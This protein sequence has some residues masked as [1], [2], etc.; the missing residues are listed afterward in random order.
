M[1]QTIS[2]KTVAPSMLAVDIETKQKFPTIDTLP[3][4]IEGVTL[5][6]NGVAKNTINFEREEDMIVLCLSAF[7]HDYVHDYN[8]GSMHSRVIRGNMELFKSLNIPIGNKVIK[9]MA[10][11]VGG[12]RDINMYNDEMFINDSLQTENKRQFSNFLENQEDPIEIKGGDADMYRSTEPIVSEYLKQNIKQPEEIDNEFEQK[13]EII[14][15]AE[16]IKEEIIPESEGIKEDIIPEAEGIIKAVV[17]DDVVSSL[18]LPIDINFKQIVSIFEKNADFLAF[19][20][21]L[22]TFVVTYLGYDVKSENGEFNNEEDINNNIMNDAINASFDYI[23]NDFTSQTN[24]I[25]L[26][27]YGDIFKLLKKSYEIIT[28][29]TNSNFE[30]N[31]LDILN[32]PEILYQFI[33]F[34]VSY[35]TV[36]NYDDFE[37]LTQ[38]I[39]VGGEDE[40]EV[41]GDEEEGIEEGIEEDMNGSVNSQSMSDITGS[42]IMPKKEKERIEI[43][44]NVFITHNN[45]LTT[46]TRG[47]FIKLGIWKKIFFNNRNASDITPEEYIFGPNQINEITYDKLTQLYPVSYKN[48]ELLILEILILK[49][50]LVEMSP[51][52]TLSFGSKIDDDL[53]NYMDTFYYDY[54][55]KN[56]S[57]GQDSSFEFE[58]DVLL[59]PDLEDEN[60]E[61]EEL[62]L[63][64]DDDCEGFEGEFSANSD[65]TMEGGMNL[66]DRKEMIAAKE[67][68]KTSQEQVIPS[69][70]QVIPSQPTEITTSSVKDSNFDIIEPPKPTP[71]PILFNKLKKTYQNNIH[72]IKE[73]QNS[74]IPPIEELPDVKSLY[75]L[76]KLNETLM[77]REGSQAFKIPAPKYKFVINNAANV[78]SNINGSRMFTPYSFI[79]IIDK[80]IP[81]IEEIIKDGET[82]NKT[83][84]DEEIAKITS[85]IKL[86]ESDKTLK[87]EIKALNDKKRVNEI[88]ISEY[89]KLL[90]LKYKEK[91]IAR[92]EIIPL[93]NKLFLL[94]TISNNE[95]FYNDFKENYKKWFKDS[96]PI[97]GLYRSLQRGI[98]CPT[99]SMMDAM[100]NCSLK[101]RSTEPKEVGTSYSEIVYEDLDGVRISFGGVVLNY[102]ITVNGEK[103]LTAKIDYR[104]TC[105]NPLNNQKDDTVSISTLGI[106]VSES[107]DLK[108][109]VAYQGVVKK[110]RELFSNTSTN[111]IPRQVSSELS[112]EKKINVIKMLWQNLQYQYNRD[113]FNSLLS[114]TALKTMGDYLQECQAC[115]KFGG[116]VNT[117]DEFPDDVNNMLLEKNLVNELIYRSVSKGGSVIPY[118]VKSGDGLRLGIQGDRPSGF[119]SI[120]ML[121]NGKGAVNNHA[122]TGYM[123]TS[124]TQNPSR[125][126]LVSRNMGKLN[127]NGLPGN[128]I[129]VTK[130]LQIPNKEGL[131]KSLEFLNIV[132][133]ETRS[134]NGQDV[135]LDVTLPTI[136]GSQDIDGTV[137]LKNPMSKI[138]PLRN[139][140]YDDLLDYDGI[141]TFVPVQPKD[142]VNDDSAELAADKAAEKAAKDKVKAAKLEAARLEAERLEAERL[143]LSAEKKAAKAEEIRLKEVKLNELE[144]ESNTLITDLDNQITTI[145]E[146]IKPYFLGKTD[147][148][149]LRTFEKALDLERKKKITK[150]NEKTINKNITMYET[151]IE[152]LKEL[153]TE[154][155]VNE[156]KRLEQTLAE[157]EQKKQELVQPINEIKLQI[158]KLKK[159]KGG[160]TLS[161][162]KKYIYRFTKRYH[163]K[164]N[165]LTK[166]QKKTK[167]PKKTRKNVLPL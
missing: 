11:P 125:S 53:K 133:R 74:E 29:K 77:Y 124:S 41:E 108:A 164:G 150:S 32:S 158:D 40:E 42:P 15:E 95:S 119:R 129:Y 143:A 120:Y 22:N 132:K 17:Y 112:A 82:I 91:E 7:V 94:K 2:D 6:K 83:K 71:M 33:V 142:E 154:P 30:N 106:K 104:L 3:D 105:D 147:Y 44:E 90:Q 62:F 126:L 107:N 70:E 76:L 98:F 16:G 139:N 87:L 39:Q 96:Q 162:K 9:I 28:K 81:E 56:L 55:V 140:A 135:K 136:Q 109:R 52:K 128:V 31:P 127:K 117:T 57:D 72:T 27:F 100:D 141:S 60:K 97:F 19:H 25:N 8:L 115:F 79:S 10:Y 14:P 89:N 93:K 20:S 46:I 54:F 160:G 66:E 157:L 49:R 122:I 50:L 69:E 18:V 37:Q 38:N 4:G 58:S 101:Y 156:V 75:D 149:R 167:N 92:T 159:K 161:N 84:L 78:G 130:E 12:P 138:Q 137:I 155:V 45:L 5:T 102:N 152:K 153:V 163:K 121:L 103:E 145:Q 131:L 123:F 23:I 47:M 59:N 63:M 144:T 36:S 67:F 64:C 73:L 134:V 113:N 146:Q 86:K 151:Q 24:D 35:I 48:N 13:E 65:G 1:S 51:S 118:D 114:A 43:P 21:S 80:L 88:T 116:Y 68:E 61:S 99:S 111:S 148:S 110:I 166:R 165:K 26:Y 85:E 34:Y